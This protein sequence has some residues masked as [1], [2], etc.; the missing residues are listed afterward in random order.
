MHRLPIP[1]VQ[2]PG[3][4]VPA[5]DGL[6]AVRS[7]KLSSWLRSKARYWVTKPVEKGF[8][9][10]IVVAT[11]DSVANFFELV[12]YRMRGGIIVPPNCHCRQTALKGF[13]G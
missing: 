6:H 12:V 4:S 7:W 10:T 3:K 5:R 2:V 8:P 11:R 13:I 9:P 1:F